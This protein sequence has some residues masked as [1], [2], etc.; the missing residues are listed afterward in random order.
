MPRIPFLTV[1]TA[2][3]FALSPAYAEIGGV[4]SPYDPVPMPA[5]SADT[6]PPAPSRWDTA[7]AEPAQT[8]ESA[9]PL[10]PASADM[11]KPK[12][13]TPPLLEINFNRPTI[14]FDRALAKGV[15]AA[16]MAKPGVVYEVVSYMPAGASRQQNE[17]MNQQASGELQS[18]ISQ[19]RAQGVQ[20]SR[21]VVTTHVYGENER[22]PEN[23]RVSIFVK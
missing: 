23:H 22:P 13:E 16:E 10:Q 4:G 3:C 21:I 18:V 6:Q 20:E 7:P 9:A 15:E 19:L 5:R 1:L 17:R 12:E 11:A 8:A 14:Y 2:S